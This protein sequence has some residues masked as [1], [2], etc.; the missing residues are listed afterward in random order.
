MEKQE[1]IELLEE[2]QRHVADAIECIHSALHGTSRSGNY[3]Y[4][5]IMQALE[6]V[7]DSEHPYMSRE[8]N[9]QELIEEIEQTEDDQPEPKTEEDNDE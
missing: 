3:T 1:R 9:I 7:K 5:M 8:P 4:S 2:A 6:I